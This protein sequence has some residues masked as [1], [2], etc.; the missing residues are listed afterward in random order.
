VDLITNKYGLALTVIKRIIS[1]GIGFLFGLAALWIAFLAW[2]RAKNSH[3]NFA[4]ILINSFLVIGFV[5]VPLINIRGSTIECSQDLIAANEQLGAHLARVIPPNSLVYWDGGLSFAPM[6]YVPD[7]R[8]FAPQINGGYT[9]RTGGDTETLFRLNHWNE[10]LKE[11]WKN[12]AD[13][14]VIEA[15]RYSS[16]KDFLDPQYFQEYEKPSAIPSCSEGSELRIFHR[17]P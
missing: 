13:V 3:P 5:L 2:R 16:W 15:K 17:N 1:S 8:I 11:E 6:V 10:E 14:F 7:V 9:Y 12:S 4:H